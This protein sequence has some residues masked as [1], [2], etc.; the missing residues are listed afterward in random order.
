MKFTTR[1]KTK[2]L[3]QFLMMHSHAGFAGKIG[4]VMSI[5]AAVLFIKGIPTFEGNEMQMVIFAM[6]A[7]LFTVINPLMLYSKAKKQ[8][9]TN[10]AYKQ[11]MEY[12]LNEEGIKLYVGE[13]EGGIPWDRLFKIKETKD[14]YILYTTRVN[15]FLWPKAALG[16]QAAEIMDYVLAHIDRN[17]VSVPKGMRG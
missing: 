4:P 1:I 8:C 13:Q 12:E 17:V 2:E 9:L 3:Y 14:L 7:L 15:A 10:P 5:A 6:C 11:D 16:S